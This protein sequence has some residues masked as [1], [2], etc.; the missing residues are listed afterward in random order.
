MQN[1]SNF[2]ILSV[3]GVCCLSV[4]NCAS[5]AAAAARTVI[6]GTA[7][8]AFLFQEDAVIAYRNLLHAS[9]IANIPVV[10][11]V[12]SKMKP[13]SSSASLSRRSQSSARAVFHISSALTYP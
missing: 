9:S 6:K 10:V 3:V 13:L 2:C 11:A 1:F 12:I 8:C 4:I 5:V 7:A